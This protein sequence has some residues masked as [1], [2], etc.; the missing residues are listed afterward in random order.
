M[1]AILLLIEHLLAKFPEVG[2][3]FTNLRLALE[4]KLVWELGQG[5]VLTD[6]ANAEQLTLNRLRLLATKGRWTLRRG[7]ATDIK[8][9]FPHFEKGARCCGVADLNGALTRF[10]VPSRTLYRIVQD[11]LLL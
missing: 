10:A 6:V 3:H 8:S 1:S 5:L 7:A 2:C 9:A 11:L 4:N